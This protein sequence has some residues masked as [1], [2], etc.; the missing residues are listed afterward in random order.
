MELETEREDRQ[1]V[2]ERHR[3]LIAA[4]VAAVVGSRFRILEINHT[5]QPSGTGWKHCGPISKPV[6]RA[7]LLRR[8]EIRTKTAR[9]EE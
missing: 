5:E 3:V 9:E 2:G 7:V 8:V 1:A 6:T 4:A